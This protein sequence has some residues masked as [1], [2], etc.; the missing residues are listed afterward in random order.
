MNGLVHPPSYFLSEETEARKGE[1]T[2]QIQG[3]SIEPGLQPNALL[4]DD[5]CQSNGIA[6]MGRE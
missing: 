2:T 4:L 1:V 5:D 3:L 6:K